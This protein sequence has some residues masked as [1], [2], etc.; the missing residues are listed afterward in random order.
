MK[1]M[2]GKSMEKIIHKVFVPLFLVLMLVGS[3]LLCSELDNS[4]N[5][6]IIPNR[7]DGWT[8]HDTIIDLAKKHKFNISIIDVPNDV[9][10]SK[11]NYTSSCGIRIKEFLKDILL[12]KGLIYRERKNYVL[13]TE[14]THIEKVLATKIKLIN[15]KSGDIKNIL[16]F[17]SKD[18]GINITIDEE[19]IQNINSEVNIYLQNVSV[20]ACLQAILYPKGLT[21][22]VKRKEYIIIKKRD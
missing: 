6:A 9:L 16:L 14:A 2:F 5:E 17:L 18:C 19:A 7:Y 21:Y 22:K 3:P 1:D 10:F 20:E 4:L 8:V 15:F 11:I 12:P 13:I